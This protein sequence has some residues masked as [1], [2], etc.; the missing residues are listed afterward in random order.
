MS[1]S[2]LQEMVEDRGTWSP[3]GQ[4]VRHNLV[5]GQQ[6]QLSWFGADSFLVT[7]GNWDCEEG[8]T[9]LRSKEKKGQEG[10]RPMEEPRRFPEA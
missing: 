2:K 9:G 10:Q 6:Q 4:R 1:L 3:G 7:Q 5:T 8:A